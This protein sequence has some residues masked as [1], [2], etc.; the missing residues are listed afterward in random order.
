MNR[1]AAACLLTLLLAACG[2]QQPAQGDPKAGANSEK[3]QR[4]RDLCRAQVD[5]YMKNRR[6]PEVFP[7]DYGAQGQTTL[8]NDMAYYKDDRR[9]DRLVESCMV[10][11]G[12]P[13]PDRPW[14]QK[15]GS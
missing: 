4:D 13:A 14:W 7:G 5:N 10:Q 6:S 9:S 8:A 12:W 11:R 3:Y 2:E 1:I 15:I